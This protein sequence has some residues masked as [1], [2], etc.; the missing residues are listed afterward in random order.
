MTTGQTAIVERTKPRGKAVVTGGAGT[1]ARAANF[2]GAILT[3]AVNEGIIEHN[4]A[5]G[6]ERK[7]DEKRTR[8]LAPDEYRVL[9][10]A[11]ASRASRRD[12]AGRRGRAPARP[13]G[14]SPR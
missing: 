9:G 12:V 11:F 14:M 13:L 8:R 6:V 3:F 5:H 7:A 2:L 10:S 4:V 1:A